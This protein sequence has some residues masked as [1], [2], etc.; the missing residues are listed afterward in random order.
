MNSMN[1]KYIIAVTGASGSIYA[2]KLL[3]ALSKTN[4]RLF[5]VFSSTGL[6]IFEKELKIKFP[7]KGKVKKFLSDYFKNKNLEYFDNTE[8]SA[9]ISSGSFRT[10]GMVVIPASMGSIARIAGG[11]SSN[12]VER[13]A[14][15]ILKEQRK[16][17]IVPRETPLSRIHLENMLKI[18]KAGGIILPAMPAFYNDPGSIDDLANFI[19]GRVLDLL[20]ITGHNLYQ[21][22][23]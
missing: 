9:S 23:E 14:D 3:E 17:I 21:K 4:A 15:V 12:L 18:S 11:I 19:A 20:D 10:D 5:L 13:A 7:E 22:W 8:L 6:I 16:L 1:K 2:K